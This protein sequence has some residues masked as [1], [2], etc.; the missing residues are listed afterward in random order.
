MRVGSFA[1]P[2]KNKLFRSVNYLSYFFIA[3]L[4][5]LLIKTNLIIAMTDPPL[6]GIIGA[7]ASIAKK[8][9]FIYYIQDMHPEMAIASGMI[10]SGYITKLWDIIHKM[11]LRRADR[12]L[13]IGDDMRD[14]IIKKG[15]SYNKIVVIRHGTAKYIAGDEIDDNLINQIRKPYKF[16]FMHAGNIGYYG[17]WES[18]IEAF[19]EVRNKDIGFIFVGEGKKKKKLQEKSQSCQN[20]KFLPFQPREKVKSVLKAADVHLIT[21]K[22]G[23]EGLVVPSKL[24]PILTAQKAILATC[25]VQSDI[26]RIINDFNCG[27]VVD[28]DSPKKIIEAVQYFFNKRDSLYTF[29]ENSKIAAEYYNQKGQL[30]ILKR[31]IKKFICI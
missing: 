21:I 1:Y 20:I 27:L 17:A 25:P 24:Y 7:I 11:V 26:A 2:R 14:R 18:M 30:D 19:K 31:E 9:P 28:P 10:K 6:S 23:L 29:C 15:I 4:V 22:K 8:K 13:V 3:S 5:A 12:I 16:I